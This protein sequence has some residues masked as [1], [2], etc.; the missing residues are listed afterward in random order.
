[1]SCMCIHHIHIYT[2]SNILTPK[3]FAYCFVSFI[4]TF[5]AGRLDLPRDLFM[6]GHLC[7][8][9]CETDSRE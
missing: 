7:F 4:K 1:M 9:P 5:P 6:N 8:A 2:H 3:P